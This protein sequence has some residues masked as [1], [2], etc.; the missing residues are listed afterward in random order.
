MPSATRSSSL[1]WKYK[2]ELMQVDSWSMTTEQVFLSILFTAVAGCTA[3]YYRLAQG[4]K[5]GASHVSGMGPEPLQACL[6]GILISHCSKTSSFS[7]KCFTEDHIWRAPGSLHLQLTSS[8][9][10]AAGDCSLALLFTWL[11]RP[12]SRSSK[13]LSF[14]ASS[15]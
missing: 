13:D 5:V 14:S 11:F 3:L 12:F 10:L 15:S 7:C 1:W 9:T 8:F 2:T 4:S 6:L